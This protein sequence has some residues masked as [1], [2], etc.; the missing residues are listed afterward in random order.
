MAANVDLIILSNAIASGAMFANVLTVVGV[1]ALAATV[2]FKLILPYGREHIIIDL[3]H[4]LGENTELSKRSSQRG[5]EPRLPALHC[6]NPHRGNCFLQTTTVIAA[7]IFVAALFGVL[8]SRNCPDVFRLTSAFR[9]IQDAYS[10]SFTLAAILSGLPN[11]TTP[12]GQLTTNPT[13]AACAQTAY[14]LVRQYL[15]G[16]GRF[17]WDVYLISL[18][19]GGTLTDSVEPNGSD[20]VKSQGCVNEAILAKKAISFLAQWILRL[21]HIMMLGFQSWV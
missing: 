12:M 11:L 8:C 2:S 18:C 16:S 19:A 9:T 6:C 17:V 1:V 21:L 13:C 3:M 10:A 5:V 4:R 14:M 7:L 15:S 20:G